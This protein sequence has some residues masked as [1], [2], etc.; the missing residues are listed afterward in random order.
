ME[1]CNLRMAIADAGPPDI[2]SDTLW[3][4]S[5]EDEFYMYESCPGP[6]G[7][8]DAAYNEERM[9]EC[10]EYDADMKIERLM[11]ERDELDIDWRRE[12]DLDWRCEHDID[13]RGELDRTSFYALSSR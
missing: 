6:G 5:A 10:L 12:Y 4:M 3:S 8:D 9:E 1:R 2:L 7:G 11:K 13:W